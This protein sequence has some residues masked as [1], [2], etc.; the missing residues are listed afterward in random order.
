MHRGV[1]AQRQRCCIIGIARNSEITNAK[2]LVI[3]LD[4][5]DIFRARRDPMAAIVG[6]PDDVRT[7]MQFRK[8]QMNPLWLVTQCEEIEVN[9]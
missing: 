4:K 6:C 2:R 3:A 9:H 1:D 8:S 5:V 7:V